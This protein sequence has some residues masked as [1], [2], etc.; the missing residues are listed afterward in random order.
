MKGSGDNHELAGMGVQ[1]IEG[2]R[3]F[4]DAIVSMAATLPPEHVEMFTE[5]AID[6][7]LVNFARN[8]RSPEAPRIHMAIGRRL[9][10]EV[11]RRLSELRDDL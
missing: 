6:K 4:E 9:R 8:S 7:F 11:D 2:F 3:A 5:I 1:L 10:G